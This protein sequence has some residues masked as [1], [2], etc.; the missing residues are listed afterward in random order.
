MI[1]HAARRGVLTIVA[2]A[3]ALATLALVFGRSES[4]TTRVSTSGTSEGTAER[5]SATIDIP[6]HHVV[7]RVVAVGTASLGNGARVSLTDETPP[8]ESTPET[9]GPVPPHHVSAWKVRVPRPGADGPLP[10]PPHEPPDP[11]TY[12]PPMDN[13]GGVNGDRPERGASP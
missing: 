4:R 1:T 8:W 2:A 7:P 11:A 10:T 12:R 6:T 5:P 9:I 13:P 3:M